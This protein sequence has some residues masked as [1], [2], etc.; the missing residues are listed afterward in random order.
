[1][2]KGYLSIK[3]LEAMK[4]AD[5]QKISEGLG[6]STKGTIKE[7][8]A[9]IAE[10]EVDIPEESELTKEEKAAEEMATQETEHT[11]KNAGKVTAEVTTR[12][13]D[14]R[15]NRIKSSGEIFNVDEERAAQLVEA[16][17][18]KIK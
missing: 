4:K 8:A 14:K 3:Q 11:N 16:G 5:L 7:L 10:I 6:V 2:K 13:L 1:M 17:V 18:A 15:E 9:R 12:Y